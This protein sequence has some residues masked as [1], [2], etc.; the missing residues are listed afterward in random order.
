MCVVNIIE[1]YSEAYLKR[2]GN[3]I[4][5]EVTPQDDLVKLTYNVNFLSLLTMTLAL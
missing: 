5:L 3:F 1:K 4:L 2:K